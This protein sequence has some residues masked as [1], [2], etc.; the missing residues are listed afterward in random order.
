MIKVT[1]NVVCKENVWKKIYL[2]VVYKKK[3]VA[4]NKNVLY[5]LDL[6]SNWVVSG[7]VLELG[8]HI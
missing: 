2:C 7:Y 3:L 1:F 5:N 8:L 6:V 4:S